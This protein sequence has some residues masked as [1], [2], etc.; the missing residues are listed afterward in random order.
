MLY[1]VIKLLKYLNPAL[2]TIMTNDDNNDNS[3]QPNPLPPSMKHI[4]EL[5]KDY[6]IDPLAGMNPNKILPPKKP[7][8]MEPQISMNPKEWDTFVDAAFAKGAKNGAS[9]VLKALDTMTFKTTNPKKPTDM[10]P[11]PPGGLASH[12]VNHLPMVNHFSTDGLKPTKVKPPQFP[13]LRELPW[14]KSKPSCL[15]FCYPKSGKPF[16][17]KGEYDQV[18]DFLRLNGQP[19]VVHFVVYNGGKVFKNGTQKVYKVYGLDNKYEV[20]FFPNVRVNPISNELLPHQRSFVVL[21]DSKGFFFGRSFRQIPRSWIKELDDYVSVKAS[22]IPLNPEPVVIELTP[23]Q[24]AEHEAIVKS[25]N[26]MAGVLKKIGVY[27]GSN[28]NLFE[29]DV[30]ALEKIKGEAV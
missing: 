24:K 27:P 17:L 15:A 6:P 20:R 18:K 9:E 19:I 16:V 28:H 4:E 26:I 5:W 2:F 29:M 12:F 13:I 30:E 7:T 3:F 14:S 25:K 10:E 1:L 11:L 8:D 23:E 22:P 21:N